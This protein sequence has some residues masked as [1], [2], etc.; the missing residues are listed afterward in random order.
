MRDLLLEIAGWLGYL[1]RGSVQLQLLVLL[2]ARLLPQLPALRRRLEAWPVALRPLPSVAFALLISLPLQAAGAPM[3]LLR[4]LLQLWLGWM[5]LG[6]LQQWLPRWLPAEQVHAL[7]SRLVRPG[8]L[9]MALVVAINRLDSVQD[10]AVIA[11]GSCSAW[12]ST[13]ARCA[14]RWWSSTCLWWARARLPR[15]WPG[16]CSS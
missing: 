2:A 8:Y 10:V 15:W 14:L 7:M 12:R 16:C 6:W 5:V 3:G 1:E 4:F 13:S 11:V 9:V